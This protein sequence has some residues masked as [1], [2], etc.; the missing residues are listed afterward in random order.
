MSKPE[1]KT[2]RENKET[3]S[4]FQIG[5]KRLDEAMQGIPD[6]V[7]V[8]AQL[9]EFAMHELGI[10]AKNFYTTPR[11]LVPA[12]L[13]IAERYGFDAGFVDY[14]VYNIEVEALG[15][16][17]V[18]FENQ[19]PD[20]DRSTPLLIS[21]DNL[22]KIRTPDFDSEGRFLK[23]IEMQSIYKSLTGLQPTLQFCAPFSLAANLQ[24]VDKLLLDMQLNPEFARGIFD[25]IVEEVL[26]P[27]INYQK[28]LFP[29][30]DTIA[31]ADAMA[32]LPI[33]NMNMFK[34][35]VLP[36]ILRLRE[37]CGPGVHVPNWVGERFL[38]NPEEMLDLKLQVSPRFLEGQDPDVNALGPTL[39][40]RFSEKNSI[41][42]VLGIGARFLAQAKPEEVRKRV[43]K[44]VRVGG[45]NG[46]FAL[47]L[48]NLSAATPAENVRAA[49]DAVQSTI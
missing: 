22:I 20:V 3:Y 27:W 19:V 14:D 32:S 28:L 10:P 44:Y 46:R 30:A 15:K 6:R 2:G 24:G 39:Y 31:G 4:I 43:Q 8:Y 12:I 1:Y 41:A 48:C 21:H 13:E 16:R 45:N 11:L 33:L 26:A 47:Y 5:A 7:P 34:H 35:W 40:K 36:Y 9:H 18:Y 42:L 25:A 49:I 23:I 29:N 38:K 37:L 17:V